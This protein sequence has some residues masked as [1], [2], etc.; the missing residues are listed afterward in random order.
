MKS[1]A[2]CHDVGGS[3]AQDLRQSN[4]GAR[5]LS[6][7]ARAWTLDWGPKVSC[8]Q[9]IS[10]RTGVSYGWVDGPRGGRNNRVSAEERRRT[11]GKAASIFQTMSD[12]CGLRKLPADTDTTNQYLWESIRPT[13]GGGKRT[14]LA[15][16]SMLSIGLWVGWLS[17]ITRWIGHPISCSA[18]LPNRVDSASP[19]WSEAM[20]DRQYLERTIVLAV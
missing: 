6:R 11:L 19:V 15:A 20:T 3:W 13:S 18:S 4:E 1:T 8:R 7:S 9:F 17:A 2:G 12:S 16:T 5:S 14:W 10:S